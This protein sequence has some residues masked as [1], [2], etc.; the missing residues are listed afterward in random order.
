MSI[1]QI[2]RKL[3][4]K[5]VGIPK[6]TVQMVTPLHPVE[7]KQLFGHPSSFQIMKFVHAVFFVPHPFAFEIYITISFILLPEMGNFEPGLST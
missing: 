3:A 2:T 4:N 7:R 6:D 5:N 1:A